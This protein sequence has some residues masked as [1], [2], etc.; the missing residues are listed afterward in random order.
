MRFDEVLAV[1][2]PSGLVLA[3]D[4]LIT[5]RG[6]LGVEG[7]GLS[8]GLL[9]HFRAV[10]RLVVVGLRPGRREVVNLAPVEVELTLCRGAAR[11]A[12]SLGLT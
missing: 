2:M 11:R 1:E 9:D 10:G 12:A 4:P 8:G 5:A 3:L 6:Q 7:L